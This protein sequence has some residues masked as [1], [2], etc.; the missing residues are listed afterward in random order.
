MSKILTH[1][2]FFF[3]GLL[4]GNTP[5]ARAATLLFKTD[6]G[7][8]VTLGDPTGFSANGAWQHLKGTDTAS[9]FNFSSKPLEADIFGIQ[10]ITV[11]PIT[12]ETLGDY[13]TTGIRPVTGPEGASTHELFQTVKIKAPV[14]AGGSQAPF[15]I[16]RGWDK[17]EVTDLYVSY[18]FK[19]QDDLLTQLDASVPGGNWRVLYEFKTGGY[20]N[21]W[22]GDYRI[23]IMVMKLTD[24][25]LM[26]RTK[27]DNQANGP[28]ADKTDWIEDN[29]TVPVPVGTWFFFEGYWHRSAGSDGRYWGAVNGRVIVDHRGP[30]MG[31]YNL[32][33]TRIFITNPYSGGH[34]PVE[35]HVTGLSIWTGFPCGKGTS[36]YQSLSPPAALKIK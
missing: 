27:A 6:F 11:D 16:Q 9:G 2:R 20:L 33:I 30:N 25:K 32:P 17:G 35:T 24:G 28:F 23:T 10:W 26:W 18:W 12:P 5:V 13:I 19:H 31:E 29:T 34:P 15:L 14:G 7:P 22:P 8:N 4:L 36:C 3:W 1:S 21:N